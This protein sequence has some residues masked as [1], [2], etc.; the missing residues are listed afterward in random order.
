MIVQE[1]DAHAHT[2]TDHGRTIIDKDDRPRRRCTHTAWTRTIID[3][4]EHFNLQNYDLDRYSDHLERC[5]F[6]IDI[7]TTTLSVLILI[8]DHRGGLDCLLFGAKDVE[9]ADNGGGHKSNLCLIEKFANACMHMLL[10]SAE[11]KTR[12][13]QHTMCLATLEHPCPTLLICFAL[14]LFTKRVRVA[15]I[16]PL[17]HSLSPPLTR[18]PLKMSRTIA[19]KSAPA[20]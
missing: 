17:S 7:S 18:F 2:H 19:S 8:Y 10:W 5:C 13:D 4:D 6:L 11:C 9:V 16:L 12:F 20:R 3:K 1:G 14:G 15:V